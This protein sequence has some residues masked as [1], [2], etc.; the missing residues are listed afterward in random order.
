MK[1]NLLQ[2]ISVLELLLLI[3]VGILSDKIANTLE[4]NQTFLWVAT[5][6]VVTALAI[7]TIY[8]NNPAGYGLPNFLNMKVAI[9]ITKKAVGGALIGIAYLPS[10]LLLS[11]GA[12]Q[13]SQAMDKDWL[14]TLSG[15]AVSVLQ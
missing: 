6:I 11:I 1:K 4:I 2:T 13:Y 5:L 14:G 15:C 8:K 7:I 10:A 9:K 12:F 3:I